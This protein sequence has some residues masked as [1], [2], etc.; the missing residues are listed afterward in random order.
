MAQFAEPAPW[1]KSTATEPVLEA[2]VDEGLLPPNT[3]LSRPVWIAPRP[4]ER[5]PK[6]S[7]GYIVSLVRLHE[8]GFGVR[9]GK[10]VRALCNYY[11]VALHNFAPN[12]ISQ[13][14]VFVSVCEGF[15]GVE[16]HWDLWV[17]LFRGE[18]YTE[19]V[20]GQA[21]RY[22]RAGGLTLQVR[23]NW[24][25]LYIPYK[26]TMNNAGWTRG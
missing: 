15:L 4:E 13:A 25:T 24:G 19:Y 6:L 1:G 21:R 14:A 26:M 8:R 16:A 22:A 10:F 20:Q 17:H 23:E 18:L 9:A 3:E 11:G 5:E 7:S 2:L 12:S